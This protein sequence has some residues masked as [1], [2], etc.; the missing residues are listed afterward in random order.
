MNSEGEGEIPSCPAKRRRKVHDPDMFVLDSDSRTK[1]QTRKLRYEPRV[2]FENS[3][4]FG[5]VTKAVF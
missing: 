1:N 5:Y 2:F 3:V 4:F